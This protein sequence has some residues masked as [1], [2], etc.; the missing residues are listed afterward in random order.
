VA[1]LERLVTATGLELEMRVRSSSTA[2]RLRGPLGRRLRERRGE[3]IASAA[4]HGAAHVRVFGSVARAEEDADS[5]IDLLVDLDRDVGLFELARLRHDLEGLL[6]VR[7]DVVPSGTVKR[8]VA[9]SVRAD[10]VA[11]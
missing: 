5:D 1:T 4:R 2:A 7:V 9:G 6:G 10:V 8:G 3:V 11:L